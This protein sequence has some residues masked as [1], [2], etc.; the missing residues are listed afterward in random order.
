MLSDEDRRTA[1]ELLAAAPCYAVLPAGCGK[2]QTVAALAAEAVQGSKRLL[3]LTHTHAGVDALRCRLK[4]FGVRG[5]AVKLATIA[6]WT[7]RLA[8][9]FPGMS[10]TEGPDRCAW[11]EVCDGAV[12]VLNNPHVRDVITSSYDFV[13][14]DE[15]QDCSTSQHRVM[16]ALI[17]IRPVIVFGDPLQ[18]IYDFD[19]DLVDMERDLSGLVQVSLP[20]VAWRWQRTHAAL[21]SYLLEVR[22]ALLGGGA[23]DLRD[24]AVQWV[25]DDPE[26]RRK[27]MWQH[28]GSQGSTVILT[29]FD[30]QC[31]AIAKGL[32]GHFQVIEDVE[33][34]RLVAVAMSVE[35]YGGAR[36]AGE[37]VSLAKGSMTKLPPS[38]TN[39]IKP[40]RTGTFPRF[41]RSSESAQ[42]LDALKEF[43]EKLDGTTLLG[44]ID[45]IDALGGSIY[46]QE[47]WRDLRRA[48]KVWTEGADSLA[49]AIR[50]VRH[51]AR[52]SGRH[53]PAR[54]VSRPVLAKG[55]EFDRCVVAD[56]ATM[57][58]RELYV[59]MTR[60]GTS[61]TVIASEP[62]LH[63]D[64]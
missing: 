48:A 16:H 29:R 21:G 57:N 36:A 12:R 64:P 39:K 49:S 34:Q 43:A 1:R 52:I 54:S 9:A 41:Q 47:T 59:A 19:D 2:T 8:A 63:P 58:A 40:L 62:V 51:S 46:R 20:C 53:H 35:R 4:D 7:A 37:L 18:A 44:A 42:A 32:A 50:D 26:S 45:R 5:S 10:G 55:Q 24:V 61:L 27:A 23:I 14:V 25:G 33:G 3:V 30:A 22:R 28:V 6:S 17:E 15:Y 13:V 56:A 60:A 38:L 31:E 11:G